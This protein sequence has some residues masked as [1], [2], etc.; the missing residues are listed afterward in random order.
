M[1][2]L[3]IFINSISLAI[4]GIVAA[5]F[6]FAAGAQVFSGTFFTSLGILAFF[7]CV[8]ATMLNAFY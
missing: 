7:L 4:I 1:A 6:L 2:V 3:N 8:F 5:N